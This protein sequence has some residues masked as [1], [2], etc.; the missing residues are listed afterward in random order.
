MHVPGGSS[1]PLAR[2]RTSQSAANTPTTPL[3]VHARCVLRGGWGG[4]RRA[5]A[6]AGTELGLGVLSELTGKG[7]IRSSL[8]FFFFP[9]RATGPPAEGPGPAH[10]RARARSRGARS[11]RAGERGGRGQG[12]ASAALGQPMLELG[13]RAPAPL[14]ELP[15][16]GLP[17][18]AQ[19]CSPLHRERGSLRS[20]ACACVWAISAPGRAR[21]GR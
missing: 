17:A 9:L 2:A 6:C 12:G 8:F 3:P 21:F 16:P 5:A 15:T 13:S 1:P 14:L 10:A 20:R 7:L 4:R 18:G 19:P 11:P